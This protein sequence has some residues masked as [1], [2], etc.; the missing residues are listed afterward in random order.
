MDGSYSDQMQ[1]MFT[2]ATNMISIGGLSNLTQGQTVNVQFNLDNSI[3]H[4]DRSFIV[5]ELTLTTAQIHNYCDLIRP[6]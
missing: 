4:L 5:G 3:I 2:N 6:T 1:F